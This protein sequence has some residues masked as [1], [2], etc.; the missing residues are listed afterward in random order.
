VKEND[1]HLSTFFEKER[2]K[3]RKK[4]EIKKKRSRLSIPLLSY[5][6]DEGEKKREGGKG[7]GKKKG[8]VPLL[9]FFD[10]DPR[11]GE[12]RGR[13]GVESAKHLCCKFEGKKMKKSLP[14]GDGRKARTALFSYSFPSYPLLS[15]KREKGGKRGKG[16]GSF[17]FFPLKKKKE[18]K[19]K[20]KKR[21][22]RNC[23]FVLTS[24]QRKKRKKKK[25]KGRETIYPLQSLL[26]G[27]GGKRKRGGKKENVI[28]TEQREK[29]REGGEEEGEAEGEREG[30]QLS[31]RKKKDRK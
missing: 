8:L 16:K 5:F 20:R 1:R 19:R 14:I 6:G 22:E 24:I 2:K 4:R 25:K 17:F 27:G 18:R 21:K 29:E 13:R 7:R 10:L 3:K 30:R 26:W 15:E 23:S 12:R 11:G 28:V 31:T 9:P